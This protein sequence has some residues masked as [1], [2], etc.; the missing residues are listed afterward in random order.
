MSIIT[1]SDFFRGKST[2]SK[3]T[4]DTSYPV[5]TWTLV[6]DNDGT[7][8][9]MKCK[10]Y[11]VFTRDEEVEEHSNSNVFFLYRYNRDGEKLRLVIPRGAR[12][13][14]GLPICIEKSLDLTDSWLLTGYSNVLHPNHDKNVK[15]N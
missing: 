10:A 9:L 1:L 6:F 7:L 11:G 4:A 3:V 15:E 2:A 13:N 12:Y 8:E 14:T 5:E